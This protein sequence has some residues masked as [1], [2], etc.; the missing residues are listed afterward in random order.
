[1]VSDWVLSNGRAKPKVGRPRIA[2]KKKKKASIRFP[3]DDGRDVE[4]IKDK[5]PLFIENLKEYSITLA[6]KKAGFCWIKWRGALAN[7]P[8]FKDEYLKYMKRKNITKGC[9]DAD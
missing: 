8:L 9:A 4:L 5:I 7:S 1:M 3:S 6:A 2:R